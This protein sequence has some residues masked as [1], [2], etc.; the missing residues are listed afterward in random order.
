MEFFHHLKGQTL[1]CAPLNSAF[2]GANRCFIKKSV[3]IIK[4]AN[5]VGKLTYKRDL[6]FK[7][8]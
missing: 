4:Q 5:I 8:Q 6:Y 7:Y 2:V 1:K 3:T